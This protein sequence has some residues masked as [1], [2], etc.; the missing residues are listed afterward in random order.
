MKFVIMAHEKGKQ[1]LK[2]IPVKDNF[3]PH[4]E[5]DARSHEAKIVVTNKQTSHS[6][7]RKIAMNILMLA[8][9]PTVTHSLSVAYD[10][11]VKELSWK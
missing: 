6:A 3:S 10:Q 4:F 1:A 9:Q 8:P 11:C 5:V 2:Q 7:E